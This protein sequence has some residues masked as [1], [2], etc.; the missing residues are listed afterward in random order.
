MFIPVSRPTTLRLRDIILLVYCPS[1]KK[2]MQKLATR[3]IKDETL[4]HVPYIYNKCLQKRKVQRNCN[5]PCDY[6][7]TGRSG[8]HEV[9]LQLS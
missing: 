2:I 4:G 6:T 5:A 8:K 1:C 9:T 7:Y 3:N